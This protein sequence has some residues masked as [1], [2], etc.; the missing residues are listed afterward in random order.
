[1]PAN[2]RGCGEE[3]NREREETQ[4][5]PTPQTRP[6][7]IIVPTAQDGAQMVCKTHIHTTHAQPDSVVASHGLLG[8]ER[9]GAARGY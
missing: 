6:G 8:T 4:S 9:V 3:G 7:S 5:N 2:E 1:M